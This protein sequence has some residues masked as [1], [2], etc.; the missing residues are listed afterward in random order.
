VR[1]IPLVFVLQLLASRGP[2]TPICGTTTPWPPSFAASYDSVS[3]VAYATPST[4]TF[5]MTKPDGNVQYNMQ[6]LASHSHR[7]STDSARVELRFWMHTLLEP[8][9]ISRAIVSVPDTVAV[10]VTLPDSTKLAWLVIAKRPWGQREQS[11]V[12]SVTEDMF[13]QAPPD[14]LARFVSASGAVLDIR[15]RHLHLS[16]HQLAEWRGIVR[17]AWCP[18]ERYRR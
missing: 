17:W 2:A 11:A 14:G 7:T 3:D 4:V 18:D 1:G 5:P 15:G 6:M 12:S 8:G 10:R 16:A 9:A 13:V